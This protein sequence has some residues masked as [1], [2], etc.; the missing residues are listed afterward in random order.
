MKR[1]EFIA[2]LGCAVAHRS[3]MRWQ[4]KNWLGCC[5]P[6]TFLSESPSDLAGLNLKSHLDWRGS[7]FAPECD[8]PGLVAR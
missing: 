5:C 6:A 4:P 8:L 3:V 7:C 2:G 1:R